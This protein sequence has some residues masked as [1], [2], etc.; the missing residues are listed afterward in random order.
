MTS[1]VGQDFAPAWSPSKEKIAFLSDRNGTNSLWVMEANNSNN[2]SKRQVS[3]VGV[4]VVSFRWSPDSNRVGI[5]I[6]DGDVHLIEVIDTERADALS[7]TSPNENARIGDWSPDGE[8][9]VY[10]AMEGEASG[11]R[12]RNPTGVDEITLTIGT[13][14]RPRWSGNGQW[15]AFNRTS[16]GGSIDL[17]VVDK[18]GNNERVVA[19]GVSAKTVHDWSPD[20]KHIVY[21]SETSGD[22]E[23]F[24][25]R[26]DGKDSEQLT[27]NRVIDAA[28][29]WSS[30]GASILF[31]SEGDGSFDVYSM[32][33]DGD[34]QVRK[35]MIP[36]LIL[37][38]TW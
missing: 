8:W 2:G 22:D 28:P 33:K 32:S 18:D 37:E 35:T 24:V 27:S 25:V 14:S 20:S 31:L 19:T 29:V 12:R 4:E 16:G 15:I 26:P 6:V 38:A 10:A 9:L 21:V 23:I 5:E 11:I 36:D 17:V 34:Q 3:A 7:L 30:D 1:A 13:D